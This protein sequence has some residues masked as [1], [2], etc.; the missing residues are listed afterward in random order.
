M[1]ISVQPKSRGKITD[2]LK[3]FYLVKT[4]RELTTRELRLL[5]FLLHCGLNNGTIPSRNVNIEE[6]MIL[7][8]LDESGFIFY[9]RSGELVA[10]TEEY[11]DIICEVLKHS[12]L[13]K[14]EEA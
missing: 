7:E 5:P 4:K 11:F 10:I 2:E 13:V 12:Y 3:A 6:I 8:S 14:A 1:L 9:S